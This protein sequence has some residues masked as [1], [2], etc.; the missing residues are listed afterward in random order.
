M[1][2]ISISSIEFVLN[3]A[4]ALTGHNIDYARFAGGRGRGVAERGGFGGGTPGRVPDWQ[5]GSRTPVP[6]GQGGRTPAWGAA[7]RSKSIMQR[8]L[9]FVN[10]E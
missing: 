5:S 8:A 1:F 2:K 4:S 7:A 10:V 6:G 3:S 9:T